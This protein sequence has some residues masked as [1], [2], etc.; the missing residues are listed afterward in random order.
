MI[1]LATLQKIDI[2]GGKNGA[3]ENQQTKEILYQSNYEHP[4]NKHFKKIE[5]EQQQKAW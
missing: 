5:L 1:D 2:W 4:S 3:S